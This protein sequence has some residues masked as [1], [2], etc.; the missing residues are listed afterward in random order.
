MKKLVII[1]LIFSF[2]SLQLTG[3]ETMGWTEKGAIAGGAAGTLIGAIIGGG[4]GAAIGALAGVVVGAVAGHYYDRQVM[5]REDAARK[6][7]Y[8]G[9][10]EKLEIDDSAVR[11]IEVAQGTPA[12]ASAL[13]TVLAPNPNQTVRITE[14]R[15]IVNGKERLELSRRDVVRGQGSHLSTMKFKIPEDMN[16]GDYSLITTISDGKQTRSSSAPVKIV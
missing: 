5:A 3:C 10:E 4:R 2:L 13:Y 8:T 15:T 9:R 14:I 6:Y 11:P 1:F 7:R 12:E 16:K